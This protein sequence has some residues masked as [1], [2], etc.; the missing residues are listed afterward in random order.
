MSRNIRRFAAAAS[1]AI[2]LST[3]PAIAAPSRDSGGAKERT[4]IVSVLKWIAKRVFGL[5][6]KDS[7]S[8]PPPAPTTEP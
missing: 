7:L 8:G 4:S 3:T 6:P 1:L 2:V 5:T